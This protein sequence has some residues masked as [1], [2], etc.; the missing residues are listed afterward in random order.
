[1][2][3]SIIKVEGLTKY[4]DKKYAL[5]EVSFE[6]KKGEIF[7]LLGRNGAGKSTLINILLGFLES[8]RGNCRILNCDSLFYIL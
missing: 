3:N 5:N 2:S 4:Y 7:S 8:T 1:M 6:V